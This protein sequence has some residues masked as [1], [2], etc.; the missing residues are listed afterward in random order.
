M[1]ISTVTLF[2]TRYM[3][4]CYISMFLFTMM[5]VFTY[6]RFY[7]RRNLNISKKFVHLLTQKD[8]MQNYDNLT[9]V[10]VFS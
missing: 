5:C 2:K 9:Q 10:N 1:F 3:K 6:G 4:I 7:E 8:S